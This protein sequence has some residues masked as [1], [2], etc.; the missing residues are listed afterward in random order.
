[1]SKKFNVSPLEIKHWNDMKHNLLFIG[2][3]LTIHTV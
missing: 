3:T 2:Q 1:M